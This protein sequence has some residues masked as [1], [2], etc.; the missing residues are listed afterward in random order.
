MEDKSSE[1]VR[2][3][4]E[5]DEKDTSSEKAWSNFKRA[6]RRARSVTTGVQ[7]SASPGGGSAKVELPDTHMGK[8]SERR[9][10]I[11][12]VRKHAEAGGR[13]AAQLTKEHTEAD[14]RRAK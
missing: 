10:H 3:R 9:R 11:W 5:V 7:G 14:K 12:Q 8:R 4:S 13:T 6:A 1:D 2:K